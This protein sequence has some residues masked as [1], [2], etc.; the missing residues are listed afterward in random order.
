MKTLPTRAVCRAGRWLAV[1]LAAWSGEAMAAAKPVRAAAP[2][3]AA[4]K[5]HVLFMGVDLD[6]ERGKKFYRVEN[7]DG[8]DF[9]VRVG[10]KPTF[11]PT[12]LQSN[13]LKLKHE[14]KLAAT[15]VQLDGLEGGPAYTPANDPKLKFDR[16]A[17]AAGGAAAVVDAAQTQMAIAEHNVSLATFAM[18]GQAPE[19]VS[20]PIKEAYDRAVAVR[21]EATISGNSTFS[22]PTQDRYSAGNQADRMQRELAEGNYDAFDIS[23]KVSSPEPLDQPYLVIIVQFLERDAKPGASS[24]LIHAKALEPIGATPQFVRVREGGMP[25]GFKF[26]SYQV[27]LYNRGK[28]VA[29]NASSKRVELSRDEALQY[30]LIEHMGANKDATV[31][32]A[33][34]PGGLRAGVR[35]QLSPAQLE[36][37][38]YVKVSK[39]GTLLGAFADEAC[40]L[41]LDD[42]AVTAILA[43]VFYKPALVQGKPAEGVA[44]VRLADLTL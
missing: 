13:N 31:P 20:G 16:A 41:K 21:E 19:T 29:T 42:A 43:D 14:L 37:T 4:P 18:Q 32:A 38:C 9:V 5:S 6:V 2:A 11:V 33:A 23:F 15:S 10:G 39:E 27:H 24:V 22:I 30:L 34:T 28:E 40:R 8:S 44:R 17:G 25:V 36:R 7:V 35:G 3:P 26:E 12:R 1:G